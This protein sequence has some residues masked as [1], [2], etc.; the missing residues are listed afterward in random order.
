[1][2]MEVLNPMLDKAL[3]LMLFGHLYYKLVLKSQ[4]TINQED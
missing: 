3:V 1:M 2:G 4:T